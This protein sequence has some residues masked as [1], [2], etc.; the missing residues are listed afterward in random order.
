MNKTAKVLI[1]LNGLLA[2]I[3]LN[4][5]VQDLVAGF[6]HAHPFLTVL[7]AALSSI[8]HLLTDPKKAATGF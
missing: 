6:V 7:G 2:T 3:A 8:A 4:P 5:A 1:V